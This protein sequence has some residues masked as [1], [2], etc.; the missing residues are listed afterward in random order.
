MDKEEDSTYT[1]ILFEKEGHRA[2]L[3][4]NRPDKRNALNS[5]VIRELVRAFEE[6]KA[7]PEVRVVVLTGAGD[8]AFCAGADLAEQ[9]RPTNEYER[10]VERENFLKLWK[11]VPTL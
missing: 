3:T 4:I 5:T 1:A 11:I 8:K 9:Q 2:T 10:Y 6:C 7:D